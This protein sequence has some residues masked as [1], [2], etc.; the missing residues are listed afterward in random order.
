MMEVRNYLDEVRLLSF[1]DDYERMEHFDAMQSRAI[2]HV[3]TGGWRD[4]EVCNPPDEKFM[5]T[6][7]DK[8]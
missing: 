1:W 4:V 5:D 2:I 8:I 7:S 6:T 3:N